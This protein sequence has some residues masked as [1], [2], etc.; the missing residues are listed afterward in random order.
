MDPSTSAADLASIA[1]L[2]PGLRAQVAGHQNAYPGLLQWLAAQGDESTRAVVAARTA[3]ATPAM[4]VAVPAQAPVAQPMAYQAQPVGQAPVQVAPVAPKSKRPLIIGIVAV[5]VLAAIAATLLIWKPWQ[6]A[7]GS[8]SA[9][10]LTMNQAVNMLIND[11]DDLFGLYWVDG[12]DLP[13]TAP[14][15]AEGPDNCGVSVTFDG[16]L[17]CG[18]LSGNGFTTGTV[19]VFDNVDDARSGGTVFMDNFSTTANHGPL[20]QGGVWMCG[21]DDSAGL[22]EAVAQYGNVMVYYSEDDL[23]DGMTWD[24]WQASAAAL[25]TAVD[26]AAKH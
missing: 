6:K 22:T 4:P 21:N 12:L 23:G 16:L 3:A 25:K 15:Y 5:V 13:S 1:Q 11:P 9:P 14:P 18:G 2:Q 19:F 10:T 7:S 20:S 17:G 8:G 24:Q 26:E